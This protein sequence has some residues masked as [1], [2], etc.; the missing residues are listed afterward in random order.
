MTLHEQAESILQ[1]L[2]ALRAEVDGRKRV[3]N[4]ALKSRVLTLHQEYADSPYDPVLEQMID[5]IEYLATTIRR[6]PPRHGPIKTKKPEKDR[7][8]TQRGPT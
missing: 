1:T 5:E 2:K 4:D 3:V 8:V 6:K 7:R